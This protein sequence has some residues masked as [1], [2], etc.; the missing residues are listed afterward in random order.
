LED[1]V[2]ERS[3]AIDQR[4]V[5]QTSNSVLGMLL[6]VISE[7]MFFMGF[8]AVY[9]SAYSSHD[10]WP[11]KQVPLPPI[12]IPTAA[13]LVVIASM[14]TM[15]MARRAGQHRDQ[16]IARWIGLTLLLATVFSVLVV[17]SLLG[18]GFGVGTGIYGSLFFT[19]TVI[20]FAH[21][22][23]G[24]VFFVLILVQARAGELAMRQEPVHAAAIY[25]YFVVAIGVAM[26]VLFYLANV[27]AT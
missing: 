3:L 11:P 5:R 2:T 4:A 27:G 10:V 14:G 1:A 15:A 6:F 22:V 16:S 13:V 9:F 19:L 17:I 7:A 20:E 21:A 26:Y 24:I 12:G 23:G 8:L 25:W 18:L